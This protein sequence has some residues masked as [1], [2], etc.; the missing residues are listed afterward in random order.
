MALALMI[1]ALAAWPLVRR[2]LPGEDRVFVFFCAWPVGLAVLT[3]GQFLIGL[4]GGGVSL[5]TGMM[6]L[7]LLGLVGLR[8]PQRFQ[9][10]PSGLGAKPGTEA[11]APRKRLFSA[12]FGLSLL[13]LLPIVYCF[14]QTARESLSVGVDC[15]PGLSVWGY[16]ARLICDN[17]DLPWAMWLDAS[18]PYLH[19]E[20]PL[21]W[22]L[23][24]N[25]GFSWCGGYC[26]EI[27]LLQV[28]LG[29]G[30]FVEIAWLCRVRGGWPKPIALAVAGLITCGAAGNQISTT[31]YA[32]NFFLLTLLPGL[33]LVQDWLR[34]GAKARLWLAALLLAASAG[35]KQEGLVFWGF[36][37]VFLLLWTLKSRRE[38]SLRVAL[39]GFLGAAIF[40][41]P[42]AAVRSALD[43]HLYDFSLHAWETA[44]LKSTWVEFWRLLKSDW[45]GAWPLLLLVLSSLIWHWRDLLRSQKVL[46]VTI[47]L[48]SHLFFLLIYGFSVRDLAWH[49]SALDRLLWVCGCAGL[50]LAVQRQIQNKP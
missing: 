12:K 21:S 34:Q 14:W 3:L 18:R 23:L 2:L 27:K 48:G 39:L 7:G 5:G 31:L 8:W 16:K 26:N 4:C 33:I 46:A 42:W 50:V 9:A 19:Q 1:P 40:I 43:L 10:A 45:D 44:K 49:L 20:Y 13:I 22:P 30:L 41:L 11:G 17:R 37:G 15:I 32:E 6:V 35:I 36:C 47:L 25:W 28:L 29:L 38:E 24:M